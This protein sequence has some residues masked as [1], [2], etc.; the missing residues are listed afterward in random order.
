MGKRH[1]NN[2]W[3]VFVLLGLVFFKF[4]ANAQNENA[5]KPDAYWN[6]GLRINALRLP[7]PPLG[8]KPKLVDLD[9]DGDPD[10]MYS[11]TAN[12]IPVLWIDDDDDMK[13]T[14]T[15]GDTDS[16]CLL[17]DRNKDGKYGGMGDLIIDWVD[18]DKDNKADMQVVI[19]YPATN[20]ID[21][22]PNGHYMWVLDTDKD[23]IFNYIDWNSFQ[24]KAWEKEGISNFFLDYSGNTSFM[25]IHV[26]T[27]TMDN[28][29]LNWENPFLFYDTDNDGLTEMAVRMVDSPIKTP[30]DK[31]KEGDSQVKEKG[32]IDWVSISIDMD[33]DNAPGNE[34]DYD[35]TL[36]FRGPGFNYMDQVHKF[37]GMKGLPGTDSFFIDP[38]WRQMD[39][40]IFPDLDSALDLIFQKGKWNKVYFVYDEDDDCNRWERVELLDPLD[41]FKVGTGNGGIDNNG[42]SD[43]A[44]DRGEWDLDNSG[45][46]KLYVSAFDGRIH[47]YG[48][49]W[50]CWRI[51]QN[52][53][54]YQG[55]D[56]K[57]L[58]KDPAKFATVKYEDTDNDGFIDKIYNDLDGDKQFEDSVDLKAL[59]IKDNCEVINIS[60]YK[61]ADY[62]A[63]QKKV[64]S[65]MWK[66]AQS[67][68]AVANKYGLNI[69]WYAKLFQTR[70]LQQQY[71][72]GYWLQFYLYKDLRDLFL[73]KGD[74]VAVNRLDKAYYGGNWNLL[75]Q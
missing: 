6:T 29:K 60:K 63:L 39:E 67:A 34:F 1:S 11:I 13:W 44:G 46:G 53:T 45:N 7:P 57:W 71:S 30:L 23:N 27:Y 3:K 54:Y 58:N 12:N 36:S 41:P 50:G 73:K 48:A 15:E 10:I 37:P 55:W 35:M 70:S 28:L 43:P 49:E 21:A 19:D 68:T 31:V 25:K 4:N 59:G 8:Y 74:V 62:V 40:L 64:S 14:D 61:Y 66:N 56:R 47:L 33:N 9:G 69:T 2:Q 20:G 26:A 24:I 18:N 65:N 42:Q 51:D 38:R 75:L 32:T 52:A 5:V 72:N 16:D 17:I 22:W